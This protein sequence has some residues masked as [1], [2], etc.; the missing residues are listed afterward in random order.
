MITP[1]N[2]SLRWIGYRATMDQNC[3]SQCHYPLHHKCC[4]HHTLLQRMM[5]LHNNIFIHGPLYLCLPCNVCSWMLLVNR[6]CCTTSL[7]QNQYQRLFILLVYR[8]RVLKFLP[9]SL[10]VQLSLRP[11]LSRDSWRRV[12]SVW[13]QRKMSEHAS[14]ILGSI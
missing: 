9:P 5:Q 11:T 7:F 2:V 10:V 14:I 6:P 1:V 4:L 13:A 8:R 12:G 3:R